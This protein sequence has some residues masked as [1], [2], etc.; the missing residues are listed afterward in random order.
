MARRSRRHAGADRFMALNGLTNE[1]GDRKISVPA[2][3][4][5]CLS[6]PALTANS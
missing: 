1:T 6:A 2:A 4:G 5:H 3:V